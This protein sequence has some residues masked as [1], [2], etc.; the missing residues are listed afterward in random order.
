MRVIIRD[1][2]ILF[3]PIREDTL[4]LLAHDE[5]T[6]DFGLSAA[7]GPNHVEIYATFPY[8]SKKLQDLKSWYLSNHFL[9][10]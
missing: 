4:N 7:A 6:R 8:D 5:S 10:K 9:V 1:H 3:G 2:R